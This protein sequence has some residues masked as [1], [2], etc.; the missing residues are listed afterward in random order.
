[1]FVGC[2]SRL[3]FELPRN[4]RVWFSGFS[5][6]AHQNVDKRLECVNGGND[7]RPIVHRQ[8]N[9]AA[10]V[11]EY[12]EA[13]PRIVLLCSF[14]TVSN[15]TPK[16]LS[17][18]FYNRRDNKPQATVFV[19]RYAAARCRLSLTE[20]CLHKYYYVARSCCRSIGVSS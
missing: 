2:V 6:V 1:V 18:H 19:I 8:R 17:I 14:T 20:L 9:T 3:L 10:D 15:N 5:P 13:R 11:I 12:F 7:G 16:K 4:R